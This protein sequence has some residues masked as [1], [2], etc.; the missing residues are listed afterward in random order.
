MTV[1]GLS[2]LY[3]NIYTSPDARKADPAAYAKETYGISNL[4]GALS[5]MSSARSTNFAT[6]QN[7]DTF[8][9]SG[10]TAT[11]LAEYDSLKASIAAH[12]VSTLI[13][14]SS[15]ISS[16]YSLLGAELQG[17]TEKLDKLLE[18]M[19][20]T[21]L[22]AYTDYLNSASSYGSLLDITV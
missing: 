10:F 6:I 20:K 18:D 17:M 22:A 21:E 4:S 3:Y 14:G 15:G 1:S 9:K 13:S 8:V 5:V 12:P 16:M 7:I 19:P 2:N 11:G